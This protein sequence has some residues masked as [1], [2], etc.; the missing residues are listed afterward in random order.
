MGGLV[1]AGWEAADCR[2]HTHHISYC[3]CARQWQFEAGQQAGGGGGGMQRTLVGAEAGLSLGAAG[4][5][6]PEAAAA[7]SLLGLSAA[8]RL[9]VGWA[10]QLH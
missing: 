3:Q 1:D 7:E 9:G 6:V 4:L 8:G 5:L 10:A 2:V